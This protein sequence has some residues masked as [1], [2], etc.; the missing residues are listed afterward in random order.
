MH[1]L[2]DLCVWWTFLAV[3][4]LNIASSS[5]AQQWSHNPAWCSLWAPGR[6]ISF[7]A[8]FINSLLGFYKLLHLPILSQGLKT[9]KK[10]DDCKSSFVKIGH[11]CH[12]ISCA[13]GKRRHLFWIQG[14]KE[15][16]TVGLISWK[17][18]SVALCAVLQCYFT[19]YAD[20]QGTC[21][22]STNHR[23]KQ[24]LYFMW[25]ATAWE[26]LHVT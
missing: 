23:R 20:R 5:P 6:E 7:H 3:S 12:I 1:L 2:W 19:G 11:R 22:L 8:S 24:S 25:K 21:I 15:L 10:K 14:K 13:D 4:E 17:F 16:F 18:C 9:K 26:L